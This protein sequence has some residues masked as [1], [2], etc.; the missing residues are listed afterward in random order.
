MSF[1]GATSAISEQTSILTL[2][3]CFYEI[4]DAL[5]EDL[6]LFDFWAKDLVEFKLLR[7]CSW[8]KFRGNERHLR[9]LLVDS[10]ERVVVMVNTICWTNSQNS[11]NKIVRF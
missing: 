10:K 4:A 9:I 5:F 1:T 11:L 6:R 2:E 3:C 8:T 7:R